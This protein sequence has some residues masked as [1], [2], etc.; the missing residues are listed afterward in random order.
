MEALVPVSSPERAGRRLA[1]VAVEESCQFPVT[2]MAAGVEAVGV[3]L[4]EHPTRVAAESRALRWR[5]AYAEDCAGGDW[6]GASCDSGPEKQGVYF[7]DFGE[8]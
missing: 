1:A 4:P 8:M 7:F 3:R 5:A 6:K 2:V